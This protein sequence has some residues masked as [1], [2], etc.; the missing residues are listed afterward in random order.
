M[1]LRIF[2]DETSM[3]LQPDFHADIHVMNSKWQVTGYKC[4]KKVSDSPGLLDFAIGLVNTVLNL[5]DGQVK[6]LGELKLQKNCNRC[7]SNGKL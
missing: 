1:K 4:E 3:N 6:F 5:L 2:M 7:S